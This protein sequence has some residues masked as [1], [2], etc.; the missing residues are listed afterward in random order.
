LDEVEQVKEKPKKILNDTTRRLVND[1]PANRRKIEKDKEKAKNKN[2]LKRGG[3]SNKTIRKNYK[4]NK[5]R[6]IKHK[7][8]R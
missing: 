5:H 4:T 7:N 3:K 1:T 6:T 8:R 2:T